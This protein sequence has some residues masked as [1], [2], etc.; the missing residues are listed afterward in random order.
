MAIYFVVLLAF[1]THVGF[2]GS[3]LAVPLFAVDHGATPFIVGLA[4][5]LYAA[6]PMVLAIPAGRAM[7]RLGYKFPL[8]FG[9]GG[10]CV[11]LFIMFLAPSMTMLYV[12]VTVLGIAFMA[13]QLA[14]QTLA[15]AIAKREDRARNFSL[16]SLGFAVANF[17]GPIVTGYLIDHAGYAWTYLWLSVPLLIATIVSVLSDRWLPPVHARS[18]AVR[19]GMFDLL[20]IPTLRNTLIASGI[21]SAAWDVYQ[22]LMPI[23]GRSLG[24]S[25]TAIGVIMSAFAISIVLV[26]IFLPMAVRRAGEAELLCYAMFVAAAAFCLFPLFEAPWT[27]ALVSFLLGIGCGC[28]QP[29]SMTLIFNASPKDRAGEATGMRITVNQITHF[30][31]PILFGVVGSVAGFATVFLTN[32]VGLIAGGY[33]S[34]RNATAR[35]AGDPT[36]VPAKAGGRNP[37]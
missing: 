31:V 7:D 29:L 8:V 35:D 20:K 23:Y 15:G 25:A 33:M 19:G 6:F 26:R 9:T 27:L 2:A 14:T 13:L 4:F 37:E 12:S 28:G 32:A 34:L 36:P 5:A 11:G 18:E 3:R 17:G 21:V 10:C 16:L 24:L 30:I 22:F 1:L